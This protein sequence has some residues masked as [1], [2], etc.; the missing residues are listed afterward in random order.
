MLHP[1]TRT[2][3]DA[4]IATLTGH[5]AG[6]GITLLVGDGEA[7]PVASANDPY[8]V[9]HS[10]PGGPL[11]GTLGSPDADGSLLYQISAWGISR[12][13]SQ[14]AADVARNALFD[15]PIVI[16]GRTVMRVGLDS[17]GGTFR[18]DDLGETPSL[19]QTPDRYRIRTTPT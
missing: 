16:A 3:T 14:A 2:H 17:S 11:D 10:L 12:E 5:I 15:D 19:Y 18:D 4:V 8:L 6:L 9:V 13:Q 1:V 7:P